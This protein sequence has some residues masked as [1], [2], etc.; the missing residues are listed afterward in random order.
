MYILLL[1]NGVYFY[2]EIATYTNCSFLQH[3]IYIRYTYIY[4]IPIYIESYSS[5]YIYTIIDFHLTLIII[6]VAF[7]IPQHLVKK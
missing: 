6:L 5:A 2:A 7:S 3:I 1:I 4:S